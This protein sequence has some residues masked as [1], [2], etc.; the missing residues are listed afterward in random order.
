MIRYDNQVTS[1]EDSLLQSGNTA[2]A[3]QIY[4]AQHLMVTKSVTGGNN[5][6]AK[7]NSKNKFGNET[8]DVMDDKG[9]N[10]M[11]AIDKAKIH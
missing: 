10:F 9:I 3:D 11:F 2:Y 8:G 7:R 1:L 5:S 6:V 4:M